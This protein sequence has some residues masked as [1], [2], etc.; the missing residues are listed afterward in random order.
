MY[1][2]I[3]KLHAAVQDTIVSACLNVCR[4]VDSPNVLKLF[5]QCVETAPYLTILELCSLVSAFLSLFV[6]LSLAQSCLNILHHVIAFL[7]FIIIM[8]SIQIW[9]YTIKIRRIL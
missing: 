3:S 1:C 8:K 5:G 6:K 4:L 9:Y 2:V 7:L